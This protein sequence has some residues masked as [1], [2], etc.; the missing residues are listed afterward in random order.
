MKEIC[1]YRCHSHIGF[2]TRNHFVFL[3]KFGNEDLDSQVRISDS[4]TCPGSLTE[5]KVGKLVGEVV[6]VEVLGVKVVWIDIVLGVVDD[7]LDPEVNKSVFWNN[8]VCLG[9]FVIFGTN[10]LMGD[11]QH[12]VPGKNWMQQTRKK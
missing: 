2:L 9:D 5:G 7:G 8:K 6:W 11:K 3:E 1:N 12:F 10:S 4:W